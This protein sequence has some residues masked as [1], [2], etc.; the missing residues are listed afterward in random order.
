MQKKS[1]HKAKGPYK[2]YISQA[3]YSKQNAMVIGN[4]SVTANQPKGH[5]PSLTF[6]FFMIHLG[7]INLYQ[8]LSRHIYSMP[9]LNVYQMLIIRILV[10][11]VTV[12]IMECVWL[13]V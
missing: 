11:G 9:N 4:T 2:A 5:D 13:S 8:A 6:L 7:L 3:N 12:Y 1:L 10:D